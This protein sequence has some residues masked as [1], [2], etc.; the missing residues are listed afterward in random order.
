MFIRT[1]LWLR[2]K[3]GTGRESE[4]FG[5]MQAIHEA[6]KK[7]AQGH[8]LAEPAASSGHPAENLKVMNL[9]ESNNPAVIAQQQYA[10]LAKD[11]NYLKK[12]SPMAHKFSHVDDQHGVIEVMDVWGQ[13]SVANI[14]HEQLNKL[15]PT[16]KPPALK[17]DMLEFLM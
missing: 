12:E 7:E 9:A 16:D 3:E 14:P 1:A 15:R 4:K 10:W 6:F 2:N 11:Q 5:T 13:R 17:L 8:T